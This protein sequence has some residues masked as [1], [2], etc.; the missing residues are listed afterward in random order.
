ML[1]ETPKRCPHCG[2]TGVVRREV[3]VAINGVS[4][5]VRFLHKCGYVSE[6]FLD[7]GG[8]IQAMT[9]KVE[10]AVKEKEK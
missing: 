6:T 9:D 4:D 3:K 1:R 7:E 5:A 2:E 10:K 8:T